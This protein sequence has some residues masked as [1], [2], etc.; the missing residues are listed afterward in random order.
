MPS[1]GLWAWSRVLRLVDLRGLQVEAE[2]V[3][4]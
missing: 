1:L 3:G 2:G 4:P